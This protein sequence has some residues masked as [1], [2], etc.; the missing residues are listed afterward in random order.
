MIPAPDLIG[1]PGHP[2]WG[3]EFGTDAEAALAFYR[4]AKAGD[5]A[6]MTDSWRH[7]A[8][9]AVSPT[10]EIHLQLDPASGTYRVYG[11]WTE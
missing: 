1:T 4:L 8:E 5:F 10:D 6:A 3:Y 9:L 2:D 7:F 11:L